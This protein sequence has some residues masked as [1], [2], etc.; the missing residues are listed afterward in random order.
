MSIVIRSGL[1]AAIGL[2][3]VY[4]GLAYLGATASS[5]Y[6]ATVG[7]SEL[8]LGIVQ[9]IMGRPGIC[10]L[11]IV[12]A[13][14]CLTTAIGLTSAAASYFSDL[15]KNKV[16][17]KAFVILICVFSAVVSNFGIKNP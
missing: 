16:S 17:Y 3:I 11:G 9:Q 2:T 1:V 14:A 8:L 6:S 7:Q 13:L 5:Q 15:T 12:A 10:L 4:G